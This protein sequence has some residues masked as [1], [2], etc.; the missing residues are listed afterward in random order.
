MVAAFVRAPHSFLFHSFS[1][2]CPLSPSNASHA[3]L[4]TGVIGLEMEGGETALFIA[5]VV[6]RR[7]LCACVVVCRR[8]K[9]V[10][11]RRERANWW[12]NRFACVAD[13]V[14]YAAH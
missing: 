4:D 5:V 11:E 1:L 2:P 8:F 12:Q 6:A 14:L 13:C 7:R 3:Y 9:R 10:C